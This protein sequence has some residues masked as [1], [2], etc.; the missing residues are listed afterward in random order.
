MTK[1]KKIVH[2]IINSENDCRKTEIIL[3]TLGDYER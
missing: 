1:K 3:Q 2:I